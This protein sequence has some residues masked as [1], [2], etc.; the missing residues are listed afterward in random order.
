MLITEAITR[1]EM[2]HIAFFYEIGHR[3]NMIMKL[4]NRYE[5]CSASLD[6]PANAHI[7]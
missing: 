2:I 7:T 4:Q 3:K 5:Q 6:Q 1:N